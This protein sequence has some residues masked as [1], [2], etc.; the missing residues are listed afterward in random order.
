MCE[1][2]WETRGGWSMGSKMGR[3]V[4]WAEQS[5]KPS[6]PHWDSVIYPKRNRKSWS[7]T[8]RSDSSESYF[9]RIRPAVMGIWIGRAGPTRGREAIRLRQVISAKRWWS[10]AQKCGRE[11]AGKQRWCLSSPPSLPHYPPPSLLPFFP[12]PTFLLAVNNTIESLL[13]LAILLELAIQ[14]RAK[15]NTVPA[16]MGFAL[17]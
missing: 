13:L 7:L 5:P 17:C 15:R 4:R 3:P 2:A 11:D 8:Q 12:P 9:T 10:P 14:R 1:Q 6:V 16:V